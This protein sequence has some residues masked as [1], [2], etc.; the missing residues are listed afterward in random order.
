L[1]LVVNEILDDSILCN[2]EEVVQS[3]LEHLRSIGVSTLRVS[4]ESWA[5]TD[6]KLLSRVLRLFHKGATSRHEVT[7]RLSNV[8]NELLY[9]LRHSHDTGHRHLPV[10]SLIKFLAEE[11]IPLDLFTCMSRWLN[12]GD[13]NWNSVPVLQTLLR[14]GTHRPMANELSGSLLTLQRARLW[15]AAEKPKDGSQQPSSQSLVDETNPSRLGETK[16]TIW[17]NMAQGMITVSK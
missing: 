15:S 17:A 12:E 14:R 7:R 16:G 3:S 10:Q 11:C 1:L 2:K 8:P 9:L 5:G 6:R 4:D 13:R